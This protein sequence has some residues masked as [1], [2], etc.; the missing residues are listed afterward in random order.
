MKCEVCKA[1][2][3]GENCPECGSSAKPTR[4]TPSFY[5]NTWFWIA[6]AA[7]L[8]WIVSAVGQKLPPFDNRANQGQLDEAYAS[9]SYDYF[10]NDNSITLKSNE[11]VHSVS[12]SQNNGSINASSYNSPSQSESSRHDTTSQITV[13]DQSSTVYI[14]PSGKRYH[15]SVSCGGKNSSSTTLADAKAL[16]KTPCQKCVNNHNT[17]SKA[18][19]CHT[20]N[21]LDF[22]RQNI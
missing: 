15:I 2:F 17:E 6:V 7:I 5:K 12:S 16:G 22:I 1:E 3:T 20:F 4:Y 21:N 11:Q 13:L 10:L 9:K 18:E 14:T 19:F 8:L